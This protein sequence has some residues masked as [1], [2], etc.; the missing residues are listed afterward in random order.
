MSAAVD[1]DLSLAEQC[2]AIMEATDRAHRELERLRRVPP[3]VR[4]WTGGNA[5]LAHLVECENKARWEDPDND[6]GP[7]VLKMDFSLPQAQWLNDMYGRIKRG[8]KRNVL[9]SMDHMGNRWSGLLEEV[10]V[11]TDELGYSELTATFLSDFE[12][13]KTKLLWATPPMPA[14]F[15]PIKVFGLAG[16]APWV[17]LT[18]LHINLVRENSSLLTFPDDPLNPSAWWS[19]YDMA[20]WTV[21]VKPT[22]F[23]EWMAKGVPW[24]ILTSRFKYWHEAAQSILD[25]AELSLRWRRWFTGDP[26]P[27]P[28]AKVRHGALVVWIEDK[29]GVEAGT[30]NGGTL[31]DGLL[32]T[33]RQYTEDFVENLE[34]QI[35]DMPVVAD[36]RV[37]GK[38]LTDPRVPY[39]YYPPDSPGV[40]R[41]S[42]KQRPARAV[43]LVTGGHSMPGVNETMSSLTQGIFDIV[44]NALQIG[45]IGGS[46]DALLKPFYE[47]TVLAWIAVKLFQRAQVSGDFRYFEYFI[48]S[49]GKAYTLDSLMVLRAGAFET[50]TIFSGAMEITNAAPYVIGA[51]GVGHFDKGDRVATRI[52]G[53]LTRR[54]HVERVSKTVLEWDPDKFPEYEIV[55]G[56][57]RLQEDPLARLMRHIDKN[58]SDLKEAGVF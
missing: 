22:S 24:A 40:R 38:R 58:R 55:L 44:G 10:S 51:S 57:E 53:D 8:E 7:G 25:D 45:S 33:V 19:G 9:V 46:I 15:Q 47:D 6:T 56:G 5:D 36:Y 16:P 37:P 26:L 1:F 4:M 17:C 27:W 42:F 13:L 29:S 52:P 41:S 23:M 14:A 11:D 21:V 34:E 28:G 3:L 54:V 48:A 43:Q 32:R 50:R 49:A 30:S 12:Q 39:V 31:F 20:N 2:A 35:T 18:A